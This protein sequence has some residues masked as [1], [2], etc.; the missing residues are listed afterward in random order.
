MLLSSTTKPSRFRSCV[1]PQFTASCRLSNPYPVF[2]TAPQCFELNKPTYSMENLL[3]S[4]HKAALVCQQ[5]PQPTQS[6]QRQP[7]SGQE[8]SQSSL[9][10]SR[11]SADPPCSKL[12]HTQMHTKS[13]TPRSSG[14]HSTEASRG[15]MPQPELCRSPCAALGIYDA[16][17]HRVRIDCNVRYVGGQ[18]EA[19]VGCQVAA[20]GLARRE[21]VCFLGPEATL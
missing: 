12:C 3:Y 1:N 8:Y 10:Q 17:T 11:L 6:Q 15:M 2:L 7:P 20:G 21:E 16:T 5:Q 14:S 18:V 9:Q 19:V 13:I 4:W